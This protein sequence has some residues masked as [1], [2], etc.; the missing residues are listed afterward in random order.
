MWAVDICCAPNLGWTQSCMAFHWLSKSRQVKYGFTSAES[1]ATCEKPRLLPER[2]WRTSTVR[3]LETQF[4][5]ELDLTA[6]GVHVQFV[7]VLEELGL[8]D[9][10]PP[11]ELASQKNSSLW[12]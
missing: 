7:G 8:V 12:Q 6:D 4:L 5:T 10:P 3:L 11:S 2:A 9:S 1:R